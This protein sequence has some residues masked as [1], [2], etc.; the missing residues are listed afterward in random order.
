MFPDERSTRPRLAGREVFEAGG[1]P[2]PQGGCGA[3]RPFSTRKGEMWRLST[4]TGIACVASTG[5]SLVILIVALAVY[6]CARR[7]VGRRRRVKWLGG[8]TGRG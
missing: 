6:V 5:A 1:T 7:L 3:F 2:Q 4:V 8:R